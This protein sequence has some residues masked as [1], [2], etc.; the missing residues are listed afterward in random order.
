MIFI[1]L[2]CRCFIDDA[3]I[4]CSVNH[5]KDFALCD[6]AGYNSNSN[7]TIT[8]IHVLNHGHRNELYNLGQS[9]APTGVRSPQRFI[10]DSTLPMSVKSAQLQFLDFQRR[11]IDGS[12]CFK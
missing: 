4:L 10:V 2:K 3:G 11:G 8:T 6:K 12:G 7:R 5:F 1:S 9:T